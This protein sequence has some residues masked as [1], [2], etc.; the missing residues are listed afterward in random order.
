MAD[1]ALVTQPDGRLGED[2]HDDIEIR[3]GRDSP[4]EPAHSASSRVRGVP[5]RTSR[6]VLARVR[7]MS[8]DAHD[9]A[10]RAAI[11]G[12][13]RLLDPAVRQSPEL[14]AELLHPDFVE[15]GASGRRWSRAEM[16][17]ALAAGQPPAGQYPA[18]QSSAGQ[19][20][21]AAVSDLAGTRLADD[22]VLVTY[23]SQRESRRCHR[24]S[25]WRRTPDGWRV[26]FHQGTIIP[27]A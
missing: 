11:A 21:V 27:P 3:F 26:Y 15:F 22:I 24:S 12:E 8:A 6:L 13:L 7:R 14:T 9:V 10:V 25:I 19:D 4:P 16:I 18:G 1:A 5:G 2:V 20:A 23:L 17:E